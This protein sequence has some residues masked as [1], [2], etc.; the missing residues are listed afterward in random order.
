MLGC[1]VILLAQCKKE[2]NRYSGFFSQS[3]DSTRTFALVVNGEHRGIIPF[4]SQGA[5]CGNENALRFMLGNDRYLMEVV[6]ED[7]VVRSS[8]TIILTDNSVK[9]L[10]GG[11]TQ[12]GSSLGRFNNCV[13]GSFFE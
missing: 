4:N 5:Q 3:I 13:T 8:G 6:S 10:V 1:S 9:V 2:E 7:N 11:T 12:G